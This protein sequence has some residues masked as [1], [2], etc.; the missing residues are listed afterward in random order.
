[1]AILAADLAGLPALEA[2]SVD[3]NAVRVVEAGAF[4]HGT[5]DMLD[6]AG[7]VGAA[8]HCGHNPTGKLRRLQLQPCC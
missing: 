5:L 3:S 4:A 1:M 6:M 2:L 8:V 7:A